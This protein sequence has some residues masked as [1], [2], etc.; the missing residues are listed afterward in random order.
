MSGIYLSA[1]VLRKL[2]NEEVPSLA[3]TNP[4]WMSRDTPLSGHLSYGPTRIAQ[5][6]GCSIGFDKWFHR[7]GLGRTSQNGASAK[8]WNVSI[9]L[10]RPRRAIKD[11]SSSLRVHTLGF[12]W[13][14]YFDWLGHG[15]EL[16]GW[17][18]P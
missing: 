18:C 5:E 17:Y 10:C 7:L 14:L 13:L 8:F 1:K 2:R 6:F 15:F 3:R 12:G 16:L 9:P 4:K 11:L